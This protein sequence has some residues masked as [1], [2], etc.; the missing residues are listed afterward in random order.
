MKALVKEMVD[1]FGKVIIDIDFIDKQKLKP[2]GMKVREL[3]SDVNLTKE[4]V[5]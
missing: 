3:S 2:Y 4:E 5:Y 1:S